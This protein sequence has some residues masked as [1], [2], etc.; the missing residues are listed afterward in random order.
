[1]SI[2]YEALKKAERER[3]LLP[4][5]RP[6]RHVVRLTRQ[7]W[8]GIALVSLLIGVT[9]AGGM[10]A[11]VWLTPRTVPLSSMGLLSTASPP[12]QDHRAH[13]DGEPVSFTTPPAQ[14]VRTRL[15]SRVEGVVSESA[16]VV[17]PPPGNAPAARQDRPAI[18]TRPVPQS[19]AQASA[20]A[21]YEK[22]VKAES[23]GRWD[24]AMRYYQQAIALQPTLPEAH[25]N[26]GH[27]YARQHQLAAAIEEFHAA[28]AA[29]P[30]YA[31]ARN[32][33]GSTYLMT[34]QEPLA[35]QEFLAALRLDRDYATPYY[36]LASV[37]ARRGDV[38]QA[39]AFLRKAM[40]LEP[41]VLSWV[42]K[43]PDFDSLRATPEFQRLRLQ[44]HAER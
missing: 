9:L 13:Q 42:R 38:S 2:I 8:T 28:V 10:S 15:P 34:G 22:A 16:A 24:E 5:G 40:A 12:S 31:I 21:A 36:N 44:R 27:L 26:L 41:A 19:V 43:D 30:D 29:K 1:M 17:T 18:A 33:L 39:M 14:L 7:R 6:L 23:D 32:N 37:Y 20:A 35:V 25:N 11:W 3:E 4:R